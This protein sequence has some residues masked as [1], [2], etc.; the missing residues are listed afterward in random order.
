VWVEGVPNGSEH[1]NK[2]E[3]RYRESILRRD[4]SVQA[5]VPN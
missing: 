5:L 2:C 3:Y 1:G 4:P